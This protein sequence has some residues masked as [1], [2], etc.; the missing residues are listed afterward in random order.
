MGKI[1]LVSKSRQKGKV[2]HKNERKLW[3][4]FYFK[5]LNVIVLCPIYSP[6]VDFDIVETSV[7]WLCLKCQQF[8]SSI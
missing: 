6:L 3:E 2:F 1:T 4:S 8:C 7:I 5:L